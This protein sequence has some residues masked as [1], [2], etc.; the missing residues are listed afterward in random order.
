M[1]IREQARAAR[2][3]GLKTFSTGTPCRRGHDERRASDG[4]CVACHALSK[5]AEQRR[6]RTMVREIEQACATDPAG[7]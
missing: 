3:N 4:Q 6:I 2:A 7:D 5:S 1:T